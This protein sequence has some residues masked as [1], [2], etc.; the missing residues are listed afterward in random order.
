MDIINA[1]KWLEER[2]K[3]YANTP[4]NLRPKKGRRPI[5]SR[6]KEKS[7]ALAWGCYYAWQ[8]AIKSGFIEEIPGGY[9][10]CPEKKNC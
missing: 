6:S 1:E 8:N 7:A 10:V 2:R 4:P 9:R 5:K 3:A